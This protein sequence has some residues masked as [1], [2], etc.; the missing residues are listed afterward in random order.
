MDKHRK[1]LM[2]QI[3]DSFHFILLLI[4]FIY[5]YP[6]LSLLGS[7]SFFGCCYLKNRIFIFTWFCLSWVVSPIW[8]VVI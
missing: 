8:T 3:L 7:Q 1:T 4:S 2:L 5:F 6:V